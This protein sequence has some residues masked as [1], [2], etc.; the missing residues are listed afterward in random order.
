MTQN[1]GKTFAVKNQG[2]I[3]VLGQIALELIK[4]AVRNADSRR[5]VPFIIFGPLRARIDY[6]HPGLAVDLLFDVTGLNTDVIIRVF[7]PGRK[8]VCKDLDI[9]IAELFRLP[10]GFV[11]QFSGGALTI[12][13]EQIVFVFR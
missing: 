6:D 7:F 1:S 13:Y 3:F 5:N 12:K 10:G 9:S 2:R 4:L 11:A 8:S